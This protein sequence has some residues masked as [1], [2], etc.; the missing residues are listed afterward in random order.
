M[1]QS[2]RRLVGW[3]ALC[4]AAAL[5]PAA[6]SAADASAKRWFFGSDRVFIR[7]HEQFVR[8]VEPDIHLARARRS[9][10]KD[11]P[12]NAADEL[13]KAAAGFAYFAERAAGAQRKELEVASRALQK[14][15]DDVRA[16]RIG[17]VT[18]LDRA[19]ADAERI[20]AEEPPPAP[21]TPPDP[22]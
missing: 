19:L 14:L 1:S 6:P 10:A 9:F 21:E 7:Q 8:I 15:A 3:I 12:A 18:N 13:E 16:R 22:R 4:A 20:L 11:H 5:L 2:V 17:E